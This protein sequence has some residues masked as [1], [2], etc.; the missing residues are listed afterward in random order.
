M[1]LQCGKVNFYKHTIVLRE[2]ISQREENI[3]TY[4]IILINR[5][6]DNVAG[7]MYRPTSSGLLVPT[8][9]QFGS[10]QIFQ[11]IIAAFTFYRH[12]FLAYANTNN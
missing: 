5:I 10:N 3:F 4:Y 12:I 8:S 9:Y 7:M 1:L 2:Y 11:V 6:S